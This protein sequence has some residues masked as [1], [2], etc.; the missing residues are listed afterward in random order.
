VLAPKSGSYRNTLGVA[1]YRAG[2]W[3]AAI[4]ALEESERL[5]PDKY[6]HS[7]GL[8]LAMAHW[9]LGQKDEARAWYDRTI[10]W[11]DKHGLKH[12]EP[13]SLRAEAD[14][15]MKKEPGKRPDRP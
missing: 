11:M 7:N 6:L 14:E 10:A 15:L 13:P 12:Y 4:E 1:L 8:F 3:K 9:Q 5:A 2:E